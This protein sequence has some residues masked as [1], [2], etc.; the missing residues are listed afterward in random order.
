[1]QA[2]AFSGSLTWCGLVKSSSDQSVLI[3][4]INELMP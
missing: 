3:D 2:A 1:M 4:N